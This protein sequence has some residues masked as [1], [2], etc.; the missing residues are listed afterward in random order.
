M[1]RDAAVSRDFLE[2]RPD[3][4][5]VVGKRVSGEDDLGKIDGDDGQPGS[6]K[7]LLA[8]AHGLEGAGAGADEPIRACFRPRTTRQIRDEPVEI[9]GEFLTVDIAGM[10]RRIGERHTILIEIIGDRELAAERVPAVW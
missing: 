2:L 8:E 9:R 7:Q 4:G 3:L 6:L 1:C 10:A 5:S